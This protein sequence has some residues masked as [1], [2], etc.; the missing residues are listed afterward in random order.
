[1]TN[2]LEIITLHTAHLFDIGTSLHTPSS[3]GGKTIHAR[4]TLQSGYTELTKEDLKKSAQLKE[5]LDG[6]LGERKNLLMYAITWYVRGLQEPN[7]ANAYASYWIGFETLSSWFDGGIVTKGVCP[8]CNQIVFEKS[9]SKRLKEFVEKLG[10]TTITDKEIDDLYDKRSKLFHAS[11]DKV[12]L[13]TK[14]KLRGLLKGC[15][16]SCLKQADEITK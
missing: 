2:L 4:V 6:L 11:I 14:E 15:I 13:E 8:K 5:K 3:G 10:I 9:I 1:M 16:F 12:T 7:L